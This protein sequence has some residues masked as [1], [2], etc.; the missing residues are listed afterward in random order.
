MA[1]VVPMVLPPEGD[2]SASSRCR[3]RRITIMGTVGDDVLKGTSR[4]DVIAGLAGADV[5]YAGGGSM[6]CAA[7]REPTR[8]RAKPGTT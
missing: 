5:V 8:W 4:P 2:R 6:S 1:A 3:D 7:G